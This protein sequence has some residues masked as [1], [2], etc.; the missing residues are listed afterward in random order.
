MALFLGVVVVVEGWRA[1]TAPIFTRVHAGI[2]AVICAYLMLSILRD[3]RSYSRD[4]AQQ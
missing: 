1:V 2:D 3:L 4:V